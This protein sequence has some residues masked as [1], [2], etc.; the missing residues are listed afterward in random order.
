[1][2]KATGNVLIEV[3]DRAGRLLRRQRSKNL[4]VDTGLNLVRDL[5]AGGGFRPSHIAV[6]TSSGSTLP[7]ATGLGNEVYRQAIDRRAVTDKSISLQVLIDTDD[8][9]GFLL[10]EAGLFESSTLVAREL[11]TPAISK[12]SSIQVTI[13]HEIQISAG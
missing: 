2:I 4:V 11:I 8:G 9:N 12:T 13:T 7:S 1:M 5:L 6:G 3:H 10:A